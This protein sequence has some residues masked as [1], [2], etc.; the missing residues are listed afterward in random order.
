LFNHQH[1][2]ALNA[3]PGRDIFRYA[4]ICCQHHDPITGLGLTDALLQ[5][6]DGQRTQEAANI[7]NQFGHFS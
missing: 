2:V 1:L 5:P 4:R 6:N 7:Q 3:T